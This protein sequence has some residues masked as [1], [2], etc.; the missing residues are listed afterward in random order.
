VRGAKNRGFVP[1]GL[2]RLAATCGALSI[3]STASSAFAE[4]GDEA[5][6]TLVKQAMTEDYLATEFHKAEAKL[7]KA[8][9][10]CVKKGCKPSIHASV[11][12]YLAVVYAVGLKD[13]QNAVDAFENMLDLDERVTPDPDFNT[14]EVQRAY[15]TALETHQADKKKQAQAQAQAQ[16]DERRQA[17]AEKQREADAKKREA[18]AKKRQAEEKARLQEEERKRR[19]E[20]TTLEKLEEKPWPEQALDYPIPVFVKTPKLPEG[21]KIGKVTVEWESSSAGGTTLEL[22]P[23]K[24]GYGGYIPCAAS[25]AEGE[26]TY[27]TSVYNSCG[28]LVATGG[29]SSQPHKVVIKPAVSGTLP[30]LPGELPPETCSQK[31]DDTLA[32]ESDDECA[33]GASCI[34]GEC[35]QPKKTRPAAP[36]KLEP[37]S[38]GDTIPR[39]ANRVSL[40]ISPDIAVMS[41]DG[42][43]TPESRSEGRY[44]CFRDDLAPYTGQPSSDAAGNVS[45]VAPGSLRVSLGYERVVGE[46]TTLGIRAGAT[47]LGYP[48]NDEAGAFSPFHVEGRFAFH[49]AKEPFSHRRIRPFAA[50]SL[51]YAQAVGRTTAP[52]RDPSGDLTLVVFQKGGSIAIGLGGGVELPISSAGAVIAEL[53]LRQLL[54]DALTTFAPTLGYTHG[55]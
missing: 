19:C 42:V 54:P 36:A 20:V 2:R 6:K 1:I 13:Q 31:S 30:R 44:V 41:G 45:A 8:A 47:L 9:D 35:A 38:D 49:F 37:K 33:K 53:S 21:Q 17:E 29:T 48:E 10:G 3:L 50:A 23:A 39:R 51:G 11:Y 22:K 16:E 25:K 24:G 43:C 55:F 4:P 5:A 52:V 12:R 18:D 46:R 7:K 34:E 40:T 14:P 28:T 32:C 26:V 15:K 27:H